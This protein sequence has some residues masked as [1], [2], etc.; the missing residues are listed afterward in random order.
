MQLA[1]HISRKYLLRFHL[2]T[3]LLTE[4]SDS[5][6]DIA[7]E[8]FIVSTIQSYLFRFLVSVRWDFFC[9]REALVR[10]TILRNPNIRQPISINDY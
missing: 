5:H 9:L 6:P 8:A 4:D 2:S 10:K 3:R 7:L 1:A